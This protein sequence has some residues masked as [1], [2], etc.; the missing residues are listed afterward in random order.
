MLIKA[1]LS[2][3]KETINYLASEGKIAPIEFTAPDGIRRQANSMWAASDWLKTNGYYQP[4]EK[5]II[6]HL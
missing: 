5:P 3:H 2:E 1:T 4:N 6:Y